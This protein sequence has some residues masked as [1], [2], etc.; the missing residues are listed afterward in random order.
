MARQSAATTAVGF[1]NFMGYLG[2]FAGD[3]MTG[4]LKDRHEW[5]VPLMSWAGCAFAAAASVAC[6]WNIR[7]GDATGE[8]SI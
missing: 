4:W 7:A 3:Q 8:E 6:L 2:A 5:H 1:V